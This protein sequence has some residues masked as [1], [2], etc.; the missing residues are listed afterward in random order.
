MSTEIQQNDVG[1]VFI[2]TIVD[3]NSQPLNV[4]SASL[5]E[6]IFQKPDNT[7]LTVGGDIATDGSD[8]KIKY[9]TTTGILDISGTWRYQTHIEIGTL[10]LYSTIAKFKVIKNLPV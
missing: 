9:T 1:I 10:S 2:V 7:L 8:G 6:F 3:Q 4:S 5:I